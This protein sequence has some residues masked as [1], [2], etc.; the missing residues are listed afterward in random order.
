MKD[1]RINIVKQ[2]IN[3]KISPQSVDL[4]VGEVHSIYENDYEKTINKPKINGSELSGD[5]SSAKL[6]LLDSRTKTYPLNTLENARKNNNS[7]ILMNANGNT[8]LPFDELL[9]G[10]I[11]TKDRFDIKSQVGDY[12]FKEIKGV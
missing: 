8:L 5:N 2:E 7:I 3:A 11:E 4:S 1:I 10:R 6:S 12:I 9:K